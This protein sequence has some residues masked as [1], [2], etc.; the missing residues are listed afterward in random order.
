MTASPNR[1]IVK[2]IFSFLR[3][4]TA[5]VTWA[6]VSPEIYLNA[7]VSVALLMVAAAIWAGGVWGSVKFKIPFNAVGNSTVSSPKYCCRWFAISELL[8][9]A[10]KQSI[11]RNNCIRKPGLPIAQ[12]S[13]LSSNLTESL[14][15]SQSDRF[16]RVWANKSLAISW[17]FCS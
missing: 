1:S 5:F 4:S 7:K 9:S 2:P 3:R 10:G 14:I 17:V 11:K 13:N 16:S 12:S 8:F 15:L 6:I